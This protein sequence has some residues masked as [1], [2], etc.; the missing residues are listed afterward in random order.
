MRKKIKLTLAFLISLSPMLLNQYGGAKGVQEISGFINLMTPI[1]IISVMLFAVGVW[2]PFE[3]PRVGYI[4]G[5]AG[6]IGI[7]LSEVWQFLTWHIPTVTGEFGLAHSVQLAFSEF[8]IGLAVS[9]AMV[10][11]WFAAN[12]KAE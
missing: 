12:R 1:G 4:L 2:E 5:A 6:C 9:L 10:V 11:Y 3:K 7:V 8:Y